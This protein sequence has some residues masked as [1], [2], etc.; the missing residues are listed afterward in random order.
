M[1]S[2]RSAPPVRRYR[3]LAFAPVALP[4]LS[5]VFVAPVPV[6]FD[7]V[8]RRV[9]LVAGFFA[10]CEAGWSGATEPEPCWVPPP[11]GIV[12]VPL[13]PCVVAAPLPVA[14]VAPVPPPVLPVPCALP[15]SR[16]PVVPT[17]PDG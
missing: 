12:P 9:R 7:F 14:E 17:E 5:G 6:R 16:V 10:C 8:E 2:D 13:V 1:D 3:G 11:C 15:G 4:L